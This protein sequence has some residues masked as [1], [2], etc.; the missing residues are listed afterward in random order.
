MRR[1]AIILC[2]GQSS[3]MG[4]DK[5][6]LPFGPEVMLQRVIRLMVEV[7][8][9]QSVVVV[10]AAEQQLPPLPPE[11]IVARDD[12]PGRGPLEGLAAGLDA[13]R[14]DVDA[15]YVTSC[16]APL[17][18]PAFVAQMFAFLGDHEIAVPSDGEH[19]HPLAA[20]YRPSVLIHVRRLLQ[21]NR[22]QVRLL[23]DEADTRSVSIDQL[24]AVD[25]ELRTL[26]NLNHAADYEHALK[27]AGFLPDKIDDDLKRSNRSPFT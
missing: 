3:R 21:Q 2:G 18:V 9:P 5:A 22:L 4:R 12:R 26:I 17:L 7:I 14:A 23:L 11:I 6:S 13:I 10:A 20:V 15:V 19:F 27:L 24:R 8:D 16:D 25:P 1:G